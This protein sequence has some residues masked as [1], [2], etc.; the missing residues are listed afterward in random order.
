[1]ARYT[2]K[3]EENEYGYYNR[4]RFEAESWPEVVN[5]FVVFLRGEGYII[6]HNKVIEQIN[7]VLNEYVEVESG[8][9]TKCTN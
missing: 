2:F 6:P 1:M 7:D 3:S 5:K 4:V 9:L 8:P